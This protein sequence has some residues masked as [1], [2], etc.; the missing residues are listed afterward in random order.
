[1]YRF[2]TAAIMVLFACVLLCPTA[3]AQQQAANP[4]AVEMYRP[5]PMPDRI[6]LTVTA[7]PATSQA[8]TWRT[9]ASVKNG[10]AQITLADPGPKFEGQ[11]EQ[12]SA[13]S[14]EFESKLWL[15]N[16]HSIMFRNLKPESLY[17]YR[18]GDGTNWSEWLHFR[19]ASN[20][21]EP[22]SFIYFGDLQEGI[23]SL[24]SRTVREAFKAAPDA[25]FLAFAGDLVNSGTEDVQWGQFFGAGGWLYGMV[26]I[27]AA[28]GNHERH[29]DSDKNSSITPHWRAQFTLPENG[30][31]GH[32]EYAYYIDY[33]GLRMISL[34]SSYDSA[35][36]AAWLEEILSNNSNKWTIAI[37]HHPVHSPVKGRDPDWVRTGWQHIF[38]RHKVDL[39]LTGH[40]HTYAR[41]RMLDSTVYICSVCGSKMYEVEKKPWMAR[42]A[43]GIQLFQVINIDGDKLSYES[44]TATGS[45]YDAFELH[46][47]PGQSNRLVD[48]VPEGVPERVPAPN[49]AAD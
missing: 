4:P 48:K 34:N 3:C 8:V 28:P 19:T 21:P 32:E 30:P 40:E 18:V 38:D 45:L 49:A 7:D 42:A 6:V 35:K 13:M 17:A 46:K 9:D 33:Q 22:F 26:P 44:R 10:V 1:M 27:L 14:S 29:I 31:E 23:R 43:E 12:V 39:V 20:K 25:R 11:A 24:A 37:F 47:Q 5:T 16:Y 36:Q 41:S 2:R 15:C